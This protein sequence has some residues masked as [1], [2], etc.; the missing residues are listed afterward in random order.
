[1]G[2]LLLPSSSLAFEHRPDIPV[3]HTTRG[4]QGEHEYKEYPSSQGIR[5]LED[6]SVGNE[7]C[8]SIIKE[9]PEEIHEH[10]PCRRQG[11]VPIPVGCEHGG[12]F[13]KINVGIPT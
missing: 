7:V 13:R 2:A 6:E 12:V 10:L 9:I 1:M 5:L 4:Q 3:V 11:S 8:H